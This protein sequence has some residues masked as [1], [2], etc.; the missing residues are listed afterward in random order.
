MSDHGRSV[1]SGA[2]GRKKIKSAASVAPPSRPTEEAAT[3]AAAKNRPASKPK[4]EPAGVKQPTT[5]DPQRTSAAILAAAV[6]EFSEKGFG[7]A[8]INTIAERANINKRMLYHYFGGKDALYLAVLEGAYV[9]I[10]SA[11]TRL[12]LA[13]RDPIEGMRELIQFTW[14]YFLDHPEFLSL[15]ATENLHRARYLK[16]SARIFD[17]H[18]PFIAQIATLLRRGAE[19]GQFRA[20][21]DPVKT[22]ISIA[23]LGFFYL[24]NRWTLST[25]FRRDLA[26]KGE[27]DAWGAQIEDVV[28]SYLRA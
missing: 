8:R 11:E 2:I 7:G 1:F 17:L 5:R 10:R 3:R 15:L 26:A 19:S 21:T 22:Y 13:D 20:D 16:R 18:S 6:K 9:A 24:S 23:A 14:R 12:H 4:A 28:L 27:L 25:I